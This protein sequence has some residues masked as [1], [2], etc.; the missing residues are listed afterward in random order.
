[1]II[2]YVD[3]FSSLHTKSKLPKEAIQAAPRMYPPLNLKNQ[4]KNSIMARKCCIKKQNSIRKKCHGLEE[5]KS[6]KGNVSSALCWPGSM[7]CSI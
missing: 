5:C 3:E 6:R 4:Y 7:S 2:K 1:M